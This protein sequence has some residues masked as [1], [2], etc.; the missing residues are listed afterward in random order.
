MSFK[1]K[2]S[3]RFK[4]CIV[5]IFLS[6]GKIFWVGFQRYPLKFHSNDLTHTEFCSFIQMWKCKSQV[7]IST[8]S[9]RFRNGTHGKQCQKPMFARMLSCSNWIKLV[10]CDRRPLGPFQYL[11]WRLI[12][13]SREFLPYCWCVYVQGRKLYHSKKVMQM[14]FTKLFFFQ[15][16]L[17]EISFLCG[18][19][20][21]SLNFVSCGTFGD[22]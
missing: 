20:K 9:K 15:R 12:T 22:K 10:A 4:L 11:I 19:V 18:V 14:S 3:L 2:S 13:R 5:T 6:V 16:R 8:A 17:L 1:F 7:L 21:I